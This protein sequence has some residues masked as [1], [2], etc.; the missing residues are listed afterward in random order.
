MIAPIG[1]FPNV[2]VWATSNSVDS[3]A[4]KGAPGA[5]MKGDEMEIA[6]TESLRKAR[7]VLRDQFQLN[8]FR[9]GQAQVVTRLL[10]GKNVAAVFPTGGGKS[11]C[12][13]LPSQMLEGTTVV[14]SP[15]IALMKDQCDALATR[16]I[17][18]ARL[19]SSLSDQ[20]F[21]DSI[22]GIRDGSIRLLYVAPER[23]F[24]ERFIATVGSLNVSLFAVDEAHCISQWGHNFRPD[25][26]KL[27]ELAKRLK[28]DRVLA[29]TATATPEVLDDIRNAFDIEPDDAICTPFHRP[30]LKIRSSIVSRS[31][32]YP[33]LK[34]RLIGRPRGA[35]LVYVSK[36]KTAEEIAERLCEDGIEATAYH[37]GMSAEDRADIQQQ[38]LASVDGV[39]VATIAFG[40]G[41]D[42]SNIRYVYHFNPPQSIEAYAQ[43]IGRAGRDGEASICELL[44]VPED[45]VVLENFSFGDTPSRHGVGR[46]LEFLCGQP[47]EFFLSHYK[48]SFETD[49]RI[50]VVRTL[51]TYLEIDGWLE[52]TS[53]RYD[54]YKIYPKVTSKAILNNF[55]GERREFLAGLLGQLTKGRKYFYLN[56]AAAC[57]ALGQPRSRLVKAV[58]F[59]AAQNWID[60]NVKDLVHGY[61]WLKRIDQPKVI[62]DDCYER[63]MNRERSQV[64]RID[65]VF[66]IARATKCQ[67]NHLASHFGQPMDQ[68]CGQCTY[69]IG[70]GPRQIPRTDQ[71]VIGDAVKRAIEQVAREYPDHFTT[72]R[73]RA[74]FLCGL[75]SPKMVRSRLSRHASFGVCEQIPF[76]DV[77]KQ[78]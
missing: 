78:V 51:L 32:Q 72:A 39:I 8:D 42:K 37:A 52:S 60:V 57:K 28:A 50:L 13:Q 58:E 26:L 15:L 62:A 47:D 46:L 20:E 68:D 77:L 64:A 56:M 38:F 27:A 29:L 6:G 24:N 2:H 70:D 17:H 14:V 25:Y 3:N 53:P 9:D 45:R 59:M 49:I 11:L 30:N 23:F 19:D 67:A 73:Q 54:T 1:V 71:R 22:R 12:Y 76:E 75:S 10:E 48:L 33:E 61:R 69:C 18:A 40:M 35:T 7:S 65:E 66:D 21:R 43:E 41:I 16:G 74:R 5:E 63:V 36:Q 55:D 34:E 44:L 4:A 31:E